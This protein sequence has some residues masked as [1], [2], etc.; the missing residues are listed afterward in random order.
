MTNEEMHEEFF[1]RLSKEQAAYKENLLSQPLEEIL[2]CAR[3]YCMRDDILCLMETAEL[4]EQQISA[5][6]RNHVTLADLCKV[7][8]DHGT[9]YM[10]HLRDVV[11]AHANSI[12]REEKKLTSR[13]V[14]RYPFEY[15]QEHGELE[16]YRLSRR[17]NMSCKNAM[18]EAINGH[19]R[20]N[21]LN[22]K[23]AVQQ[24]VDIYGY[25]RVLYILA[26]TIKHKDW[27]GRFSTANK[28]WAQAQPVFEDT[29]GSWDRNVDLVIDQTHPGL[30]DLFAKEARHEFL[31]TQPLSEEDIYAEAVRIMDKLSTYPSPNSPNG[32][33]FMAQVSDDFLYRARGQQTSRLAR[34]FPFQ[35][36]TLS[37]LKDQ[38]G[39]YAM[40]RKDEDRSKP[41]REVK[42]S[43]RGKLQE[44]PSERTSPKNSAKSKQT[45]R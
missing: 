25:E 11:E 40:I 22:T 1:A 9:S 23:A 6:L 35:S 41:L 8:Q 24:V 26:L 31:L 15:A 44:K 17:I 34:Y 33:H 28:Q 12:L 5:M 2:D 36:F 39:L 4:S 27:D 13:P 43:I 29:S 18:E 10:D 38:K 19:Y 21:S 30:V 16:E 3:E 42:P 37:R 14:Y 45:E 32:T 7:C 20:D